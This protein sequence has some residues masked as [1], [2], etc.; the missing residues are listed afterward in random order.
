MSD[1]TVSSGIEQ[2]TATVNPTEK[3]GLS[4]KMTV[5]GEYNFGSTLAEAIELF[6]EDVVLHNFKQQARISFQSVLRRLYN[7]PEEERQAYIS[8]W[9]LGVPPVRKSAVD[10]AKDL[11]A[12]MSDEQRAEF[13]KQWKAQ[14][15]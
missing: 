9:K 6:G 4:E 14:N 12:S 8:N 7:K 1:V 2:V 10:K 15:K 11:F 13:L 3:N 5:S